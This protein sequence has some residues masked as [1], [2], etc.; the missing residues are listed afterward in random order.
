MYVCMVEVE[1]FLYYMQ[2][3]HNVHITCIWTS[4]LISSYS[5]ILKATFLKP[6]VQKVAM[7]PRFYLTAKW[8]S[9]KLLLIC[10]E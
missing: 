6:V 9:Y 5:L 4:L 3:L 2:K 1:T 8:W 10:G 7:N